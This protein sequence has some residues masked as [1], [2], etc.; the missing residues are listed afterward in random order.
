MRKQIIEN[1]GSNVLVLV[2][3]VLITLVMTP[4]LLRSMG[5]HDFGIWEMV[6]AII[7]YMGLLDLGMKPAIT[8]YAAKY[9]GEENLEKLFELFATSLV[10]MGGIGLILCIAFAIWAATGADILSE[11]GSSKS[12]YVTF[13]IIIAFQLL[14]VF[15]GYVAECFVF[16]FQKYALN[17]LLILVNILAG[18][19]I[20]YMFI[21]QDNALV[22]VALVGTLGMLV[23]YVVLFFIVARRND[24]AIYFRYSCSNKGMFQQLVRFG[25]K[26]FLQ[27]I[28]SVVES[29]SSLLLVGWILGPA[30]IPYYA[31]PASLARYLQTI[32]WAIT[33]TFMPL[34]TNLLASKESEKVIDVYLTYSR[35]II[36][37]LVPLG[38][39]MCLYGVDF[40]RLWVGAEYIDGYESLLYVLV[41][42]FLLPFLSPF[43]MQYLVAKNR[44][45]ALA[46]KLS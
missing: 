45:N 11:A 13:L 43:N 46:I 30:L 18:A 32:G 5:N 2:V 37:L 14:I 4:L 35:Y 1:S 24:M 36:G 9:K 17:N 21:N 22:L 33:Q 20:V 44:H 26:S 7:G 25:S 39:C 10:F 29:R 3:R 38:I 6:A 15:P 27:G 40:I 42:Y 19:V 12:H 8:R 31:I 41:L 28:G 34:F 16:G 23:R